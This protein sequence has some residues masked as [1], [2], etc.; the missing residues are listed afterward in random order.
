MINNFFFL[1]VTLFFPFHDFHVTHTTFHY[2]DESKSME[3]TIKVA[4]EDL[5]KSIE[6][7]STK[8]L[9]DLSNNQENINSEKLILEYFRNNLTFSLIENTK[10][11]KWVGIE[12]SNNLHDIYLYF[13]IPN[14]DKNENIESITIKNTLFLDLYDYQT[15]IVLIEL[16]ERN[17]NLTFNKD[18]D[19][20]TIF[21]TKVRNK[22]L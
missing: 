17:Y 11:Y 19:I 16:P 8:K 7:K 14:F 18:K 15:N 12:T 22:N 9:D 6:N 1:I 21:M 20:Q 4:I 3:I 5:E 10:E 13:E 2:N